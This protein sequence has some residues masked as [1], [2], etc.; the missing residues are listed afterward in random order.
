MYKSTENNEEQ[1]K[2]EELMLRD[3]STAAIRERWQ[4]QRTSSGQINVICSGSARPGGMF[5]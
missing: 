1:E 4:S 2:V 5:K 3:Q